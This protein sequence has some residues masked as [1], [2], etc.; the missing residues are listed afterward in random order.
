MRARIVVGAVL[1]LAFSA[2]ASAAEWREV[3]SQGAMHFIAIPKGAA[4]DMD[5]YRMAAAQAC[6]GQRRCIVGF[7][8]NPKTVPTRLPSRC[9]ACGP[10]SFVVREPQHRASRVD[11][12]LPDRP[13]PGRG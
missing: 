13:A 9:A 3:H 10:G 12:E 2:R 11:L 7:W 6:A 1:A 8:T 4:R 5:V